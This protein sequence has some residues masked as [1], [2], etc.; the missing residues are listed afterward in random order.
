GDSDA[1]GGPFAETPDQPG[2]KKSAPEKIPKV[3]HLV[4]MRKNRKL[5]IAAGQGRGQP[6]SRKPPRQQDRRDGGMEKW[7]SLLHGICHTIHS[8]RRCPSI[9]F[10]EWTA[11]RQK[12][13]GC[14]V[15]KRTARSAFCRKDGWVRAT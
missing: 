12:P 13:P 8:C 4:R 3:H 6:Q 7:E 1:P 14:S 15:R 9:E 10:W 5:H 2:E 11:G